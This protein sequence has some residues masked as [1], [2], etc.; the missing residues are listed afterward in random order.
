MIIIFCHNT[1]ISKN[2]EKKGKSYTLP[3][4]FSKRALLS[5]LYNTGINNIFI[6]ININSLIHF[7]PL[8][9]EKE[10]KFQGL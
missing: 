7:V 3:Q 8:K 10:H 4:K 1:F 9:I 5:F 2:P 6:K